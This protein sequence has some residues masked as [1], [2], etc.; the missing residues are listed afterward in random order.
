MSFQERKKNEVKSKFRKKMTTKKFEQKSKKMKTHKSREFPNSQ[1]SQNINNSINSSAR[2]IIRKKSDKNVIKKY[3]D[4]NHQFKETIG[5]FKKDNDFENKSNYK[6]IDKV[7]NKIK[8]IM[9][10]NGMELN[11]LE[12][13]LA[14]KYDKRKYCQY[15]YSLLKT[16]HSIIFTFFN[17]NDYNSKIIK[18]DLFIFNFSL[19]FII[20]AIFFNDDTM[21]KIY[22]NKG[23]FD[24]IGQL[25]QIIYSS[26]ISSLFSFIMEILALTEEK[27]LQFK[28]IRMKKNVNK[29]FLNLGN[30]IKNKIILYFILSTIFL[31]IFWY[32][33][34]M[35]C[36]IYVNTQI[37]LI[38]DTVTSYLLSFIEPLGIYLIPGIFRISALSKRHNNKYI[39]YKFSIILQNILI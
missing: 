22:K 38:K 21:H 5:F 13:Q 11:N 30:N 9:A 35:F 24:L 8:K 36:A 25:P 1:I 32:Y 18:I 7:L 37:H 29:I 6:N 27:I 14:L 23:A 12:Y 33:L 4:L 34:S 17:N 20:N 39:L 31:V 15:Y 28:K 16:K 10:Y 19:F 26:I 2:K 3:N